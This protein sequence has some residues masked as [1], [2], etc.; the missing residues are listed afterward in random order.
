[1]IIRID[2]HGSEHRY[3]PED[4]PKCAGNIRTLRIHGGECAIADSRLDI[5]LSTLLGSCVSV[6]VHD[7]KINLMGFNH[8]LLP[9]TLKQT[10]SLHFGEYAMEKLINIM[11]QNGSRRMNMEAKVVGGARVVSSLNVDSGDKNI[12]F[13]T[14]FLRQEGIRILSKDVGGLT[15]RVVLIRQDF[16]TYVRYIKKGIAEIDIAQHDAIEAQAKEF[17]SRDVMFL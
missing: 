7:P 11:M 8:F 15:G 1:M 5:G 14:D 16:K 12:R 4:L 10:E 17:Q 13:A 6:M 9:S 3:Q 2:K